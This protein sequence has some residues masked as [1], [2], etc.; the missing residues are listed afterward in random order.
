MRVASG[1]ESGRGKAP[2]IGR[3]AEKREKRDPG[4]ADTLRIRESLLEPPPRPLVLP[5]IRIVGV[6][7]N[8]RVEQL[9]LWNG[10][11]TCSR[12]MPMLS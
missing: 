7:K 5:K 3:D 4:E 1:M 11:S 9:H 6:K 8:A 12:R 10:L 2:R